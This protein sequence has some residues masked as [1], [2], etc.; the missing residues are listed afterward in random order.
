[1]SKEK[2]DWPNDVPPKDTLV[3]VPPGT[4][5]YVE[6]NNPREVVSITGEECLGVV[7]GFQEYSVEEYDYS[8]D[9]VEVLIGDRIYNVLRTTNENKPYF[10]LPRV[11]DVQ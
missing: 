8:I 9:Y 3:Y 2:K 6:K 1:M 4:R 10:N 5:L 11:K 7:I